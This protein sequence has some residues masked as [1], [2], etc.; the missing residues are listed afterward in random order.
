MIAANAKDE[1]PE[2]S[3]SIRLLGADNEIEERE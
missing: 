1:R 2:G 3:V